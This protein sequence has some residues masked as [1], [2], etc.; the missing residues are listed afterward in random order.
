MR[1]IITTSQILCSLPNPLHELKFSAWCAVNVASLWIPDRK[2]IFLSQL[3]FK[4]H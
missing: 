1:S 4:M 2:L 3:M